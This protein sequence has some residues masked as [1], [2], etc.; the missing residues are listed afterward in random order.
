[1]R[2]MLP[3]QCKWIDCP[4]GSFLHWNFAC[5]ASVTLNEAGWITVVRW[6]GRESHCRAGSRDQGKRWIERW[7]APRGMP[8]PR[9]PWR[10]RGRARSLVKVLTQQAKHPCG[11]DIAS[12]SGG[13]EGVQEGLRGHGGFLW[14]ASPQDRTG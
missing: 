14:R 9:P 1:M 8:W 5:I 10:G 6:D 12:R 7:L 2:A 13:A 11:F 4:E 3:V